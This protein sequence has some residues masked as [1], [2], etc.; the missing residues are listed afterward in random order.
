MYI[1]ILC[2]YVHETGGD[3]GAAQEMTRQRRQGQSCYRSIHHEGMTRK[4]EEY[5][6]GTKADD[7]GR[8][9]TRLIVAPRANDCKQ[10]MTRAIRHGAGKEVGEGEAYLRAW[11]GRRRR[12]QWRRQG[13]RSRIGHETINSGAKANI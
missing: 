13:R 12:I 10:D 7:Q 1:S 8:G 6:S 9:M 4:P 5:N 2:R 11:P 3:R